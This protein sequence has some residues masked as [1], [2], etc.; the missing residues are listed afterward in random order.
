MSMESTL[1]A[2]QKTASGA[3]LT[4]M[5]ALFQNDNCCTLRGVTLMEVVAGEGRLQEPLATQC[6]LDYSSHPQCLV[7]NTHCII[8]D[9][10]IINGT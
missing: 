8:A 2:V 6:N 4:Q 3:A 9:H 1:S 7:F 10:V 5:G